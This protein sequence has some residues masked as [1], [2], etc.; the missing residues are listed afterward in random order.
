MS[1]EQMPPEFDWIKPGVQIVHSYSNKEY[2]CVS[3]PYFAYGDWCCDIAVNGEQ[4]RMICGNALQEP[5]LA[6]ISLTLTRE[7]AEALQ[8][9][10]SA[11]R[12][13]CSSNALTELKNQIEEK[14]K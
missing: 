3:L 14:L 9:G 1:S 7:Q 8:S 5:H 13:C 11:I 2:K 6:P 12:W 10:L 4:V